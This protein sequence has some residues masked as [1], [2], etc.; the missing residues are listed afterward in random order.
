[1]SEIDNRRALPVWGLIAAAG[2]GSRFGSG[3]PKQ[4]LEFHRGQSLLEFSL[5]RLLAS[6]LCQ[7]VVVAIDPGHEDWLPPSSNSFQDL[8][9]RVVIGGQKRAESVLI[10][11]RSMAGEVGDCWVLVQDA[12]RPCLR[13]EDV[14]RLVEAVKEDEIGGFLAVPMTDSCKRDDGRGRSSATLDRTSLWRAQTPQMFRLSL[15]TRAL[16]QAAVQGIDCEDEAQAI[17]GLG[18]CP[19]IV[20]GSSDNIKITCRRDW[21]RARDIINGS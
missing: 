11:L 16:E 12:A 14:A 9:V 4:H 1:M 7:G 10:A 17:Q 18:L 2:G 15:L 13:S 21:E 8:P 3:I 20:A 5:G 19:L 6:E